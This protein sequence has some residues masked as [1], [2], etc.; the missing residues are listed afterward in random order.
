ML[1][2]MPRPSLAAGHCMG[3][4]SFGLLRDL[5]LVCLAAARPLILCH[6]LLSRILAA[7]V[8]LVRPPRSN[9]KRPSR[10]SSA[11][12]R[13]PLKS[14]NTSPPSPSVHRRG[15]DRSRKHHRRSSRTPLAPLPACSSRTSPYLQTRTH[16]PALVARPSRWTRVPSACRAVLRTTA[17]APGPL[18][19]GQ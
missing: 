5:R 9:E 6:L 17:P 10:C 16:G 14:N 3:T 4:C 12:S 7:L 15:E 19:S 13:I 2:P 18:A 1:P 11:N 8:V